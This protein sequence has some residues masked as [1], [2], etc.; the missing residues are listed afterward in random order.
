M[1]RKAVIPLM[2][3][4]T[5]LLG[6]Q[7][8]GPT[9]QNLPPEPTPGPAQSEPLDDDLQLTGVLDFQLFTFTLQ[10]GGGVPTTEV[11]LVLPEGIDGFY[12]QVKKLATLYGAGEAQVRDG[13]QEEGLLFSITSWWAG[14][15]ETLTAQIVEETLVIQKQWVEEI[16]QGLLEAMEAGKA[17][18]TP[19]APEEL[20][21]IPLGQNSGVRIIESQSFG[22]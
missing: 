18:Y 15:G 22:Y 2:L 20:L 1:P 3:T 5:V 14:A 13:I 7:D 6:C 11:Y 21:Q 10:E 9:E 8:Q 12:G 17:A 19:P 16:P 4:L